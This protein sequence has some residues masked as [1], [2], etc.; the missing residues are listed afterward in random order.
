MT[1]YEKRQLEAARN[2][3]ARQGIAFAGCWKAGANLMGKGLAG[4]NFNPDGNNARYRQMVESA[5][6]YAK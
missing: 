1:D 2:L 6:N 4:D 3:T 5:K